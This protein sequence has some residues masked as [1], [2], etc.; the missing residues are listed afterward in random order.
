MTSQSRKEGTETAVAPRG[1]HALPSRWLAV[2]AVLGCALTGMRWNTP[3]LAWLVP[4]P[5]LL[6]ARRAHTFRA[7]FGLF[8]LMALALTLQ[9]LKITT[10]PLSP[11]L[12][13]VF[14]IPAALSFWL[15]VLL[16]DWLRRGHGEAHGA[17]AFA[18]L[19]ALS[20]YLSYAHTELGATITT[21]TTQTTELPLLQSA[22]LAGLWGI[23]FLLAWVAG[24]SAAV[25]SVGLPKSL[26]RACALAAAFTLGL[27]AWGVL[28]LDSTQRD[29]VLVG[30]VTTSVGLDERGLPSGAQL[31]ANTDALFARTARAKERGARVVVWPEAATLVQPAD[32]VSLLNRARDACRTQHIDL[33]LAYGVIVSTSPLLLDN[34]LAFVTSEG[35]IAASYRKHHPVPGEPSM[36]GDEPLAVITRPYGRVATAICYDYDFPAM[37]RTHAALGA[38]IVFVPASDW[39]GIDP[40]HTEMARIRAIEAGISVVRAV[41]WATGAAFDAYGRTRAVL[42]VSAGPEQVMVTAIPASRVPTLYA[43]IGDTPL[44]M[45][46]ARRVPS[47]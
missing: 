31:A 24:L 15:V 4:V 13:P 10:A 43:R 16:S 3:L 35:E 47:A 41:R 34:K 46:R 18:A 7:R 9:T 11:L 29:A 36:R 17:L 27:H 19:S 30:A 28:R 40:T 33:V 8:A 21:G 12:A 6:L 20:D 2:A 42:P 37:A 38:D 1:V 39:R 44:V 22:S 26:Q 25:L 23:A 45:Q 5:F 14:S 32:E